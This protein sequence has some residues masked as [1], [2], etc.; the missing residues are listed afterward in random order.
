MNLFVIPRAVFTPFE[1]DG[2]KWI[3]RD[4][5]PRFREPEEAVQYGYDH[6]EINYRDGKQVFLQWQERDEKVFI[7]EFLQ[8]VGQLKVLL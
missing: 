8:G 2:R 5:L 1:W 6:P 4:D 3:K 7:N